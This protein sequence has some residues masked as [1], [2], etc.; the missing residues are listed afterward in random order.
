MKN[1]KIFCGI[2][3]V[4]T[5]ITAIIT[6]CSDNPP[7]DTELPANAATPSVSEEATVPPETEPEITEPE[8]EVTEPVVS[9]EQPAEVPPASADLSAVLEAADNSL[10]SDGEVVDSSHWLM[11]C[12][13]KGGISLPRSA[14]DQ[15]LVG[16]EIDFAELRAGDLVFFTND[17]TGEAH[18]G[19]IYTGRGM[20]IYCTGE[21]VKTADITTKY[22]NEHFVAAR[23]I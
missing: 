12:F 22:W 14:K 5:I 9:E 10:T 15:V 13:A 3:I 7:M 11:T 19:G 17:E 20:M 2:L 6:S 21:E 23:R 1:T 8:S 16:S 4:L 18:F